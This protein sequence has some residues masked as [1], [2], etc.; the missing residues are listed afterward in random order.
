MS[1]MSDFMQSYQ[2]H[3]KALVEANRLNKAAVFAALSATSITSV[4]VTFNG[5]GDSGQI[6]D[7]SAH[8]G[9]APVP[10]PDARLEIHHA[11]WNTDKLD[12][13]Q[14]TLKEAIEQLCFDYLAQ[15]HG[16]WENNDGGSGEFTFWVEDSRIELDFNQFFTDST[17][18]NHTF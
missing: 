16:G 15:E 6:E 10:I 7:I 1:D 17:C 14:T 11:A 8:A 4:T 2:N 3:A 18:F 5:G 9:N 12:S 13:A